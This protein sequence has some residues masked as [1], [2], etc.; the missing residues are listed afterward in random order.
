M[1]LRPPGYVLAGTALVAMLLASTLA[2]AQE[3]PC[4][5]VGQLAARIAQNRDN[6]VSES[7]AL[8]K[9]EK[10]GASRSDERYTKGMIAFEYGMGASLT[11][12]Q[13]QALWTESCYDQDHSHDRE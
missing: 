3:D 11:P 4:P 5:I 8:R 1:N 7:E 6:G 12:E 10:S 13:S 9:A 2:L